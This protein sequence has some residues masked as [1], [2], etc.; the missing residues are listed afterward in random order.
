MTHLNTANFE[1]LTEDKRKSI[2]E[3]VQKTLFAMKTDFGEDTYLNIYPSGS[4]PG[5]F[6]GTAKIHK[7]DLQDTNSIEELPLRPIISNIGTATH[8]TAQYLSKL[9]APLGKSIY[10][11]ESSKQFVDK[12]KDIKVPDGYEMI[13]FDVKS[14]FTNVPLDV[15]IE[16]L[17][18]KVYDE[19]LINTKIKRKDMKA[20]LLLCTKTVPFMFNGDMYMQVEGVA[21]G[22]PLGPLLANVFMCELE[23]VL[24]PTLTN[25][26]DMWTRYVDDTFAFVKI[27]KQ[28]EILE[29]INSFHPSIKFTYEKEKNQSISFLDVLVKRDNEDKLNTSIYR[30]PT[31]NDIYINWYAHSPNAWKIATLKNLIKRAF[32]ISSTKLLLETE[33]KYLKYV[34]CTYN[35]Y[36]EKLVDDI[37]RSEREY[38]VKKL[39]KEV[40]NQRNN[41]N[42]VSDDVIT[43][44]LPY[45]GNIGDNIISKMKK[46]ISKVISVMPKK[47]KNTKIRVIYK[48]KKLGSKFKIK[49]QTKLQ[50]MHNVVYNGK[51]HTESC[52]S[53]YGGQT[54]C[55]L[56]K[57]IIQHNRTDKNSHLLKH[58]NETGHQR[59]WLEDFKILGSG[60][61][62]NFKRKISESLFINEIKPDLNIQ[63]TAFKLSLFN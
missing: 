52:I 61:A 51:C 18:K 11:V 2:E 47:N 1:K 34:F 9:L 27:N 26:M 49:D 17:L 50:H 7:V 4:N 41:L 21:M 32:C 59:V 33:L 42:D 60:Y 23:N 39:T 5:K 19:K 45:G 10:T 16:I 40:E 12:I 31:S 35:Q 36:P 3:V 15:T 43:L 24:V 54:K 44:T 46:N 55:R 62:S 48:A 58:A 29:K 56:G 28:D 14:L 6:Y 57:R 22:S 13:S 37:I 53:H 30:K 8:K 63:K 20:L 38:Q 25:N